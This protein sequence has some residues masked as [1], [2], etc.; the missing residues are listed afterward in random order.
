M[1][2]SSVVP[3][4]ASLTLLMV[5]SA[6]SA[7]LRQRS[8][9]AL[10]RL[11]IKMDR[12]QL[13]NGLRVIVIED[14]TAPI[15]TVALNEIFGG[16]GSARLYQN[17]REKHGY[18]CGAYSGF[19]AAAI[20]GLWQISTSVRTDVTADAMQELFA[21]M[22]RIRAEA[23]SP[24]EVASAKRALIGRYIFSLEEPEKLLDQVLTQELYNLPAAYWDG[25][26]QRVQEVSPQDVTRIARKIIDL[27]HLQV[28]AVGDASKVRQALADY[29]PIQSDPVTTATEDAVASNGNGTATD[30]IASGLGL[31]TAERARF[32]RTIAQIADKLIA[33]ATARK[34]GIGWTGNSSAGEALETFDFYDGSAGVTYFLLKAYQALG[35]EEYLQAARRSLDHIR[36]EARQDQ[37]GLYF[38]DSVNGVFQGNAGPGYL[39]LYAHHVTGDKRDLD[40]AEAIARRIVAVPQTM[41]TSSPDI[42]SGAAGTGLF[43]LAMDEATGDSRYLEGAR[44]LGDFLLE[45]AETR[46]AGATWKLTAEG[47]EYYFVGFSHGPAGIGY[48]LDRLYR[49]TGEQRYQVDAERAMNHI[50][51]IARHEKNFVKWYHEELERSTRYSSQWCHGAPG[52]NPFFLQ[53]YA[54]GHKGKFLDWAVANTR[55]L[56]D[57]GV[58]VRKN[59]G[60]CHG[61]AGNTASLYEMYRTTGDKNYLQAIKAAVDMLYREIELSPGM[62]SSVADY[63]YSY[64][65]GLAGVGD[66]LVLMY[67]EG[68]LNMFGPLGYG[69]DLQIVASRRTH[70]P[71]GCASPS[72]AIRL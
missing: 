48:Y 39:F 13:A 47:H 27:D 32:G 44:N 26:P 15:V 60:V 31:S 50:E 9:A 21:E 57:Q 36:N 58:D 40:T 72:R 63:D 42:I 69:D 56:L 24:D 59:P 1:K 64:M 38:N 46:G 19:S 51:S 25:Y 52:M 68:G 10:P 17:L 67:S 43:L 7:E 54:D 45:R 11:D 14:H 37:H 18:T 23:V 5:A 62:S 49:R 8:A 61:I 4:C 20:P 65:T 2:S 55:Y 41:A 16:Q 29:G 6:L 71:A 28:A 66:F 70:A 35:R 34:N 3:L 53:L 22:R 12:A 33:S 30:K